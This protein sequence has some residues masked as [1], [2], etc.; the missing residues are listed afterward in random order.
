MSLHNTSISLV[1]LYVFPIFHGVMPMHTS[2]YVYDVPHINHC[3]L[4]I[5]FL[6]H[7]VILSKMHHRTVNTI[8]SLSAVESDYNW[9]FLLLSL[10][11]SMESKFLSPSY[12]STF[13]PNF[14]LLLFYAC[15][16]LQHM[17]KTGQP[18]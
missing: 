17:L 16:E 1:L 3:Y 8:S 5:L 11:T 10:F 9:N 18:F 15:L 13:F 14:S 6:G 4:L 12:L 7:C 2:L